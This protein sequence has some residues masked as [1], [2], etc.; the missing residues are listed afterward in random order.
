MAFEEQENQ[1]VA[2]WCCVRGGVL[3]DWDR[4]VPETVGVVAVSSKYNF[5]TLL[6]VSLS[7]WA[8]WY[9]HHRKVD[10]GW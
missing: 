4:D 7:W 6:C 3:L 9:S 10:Q 2:V 1:V 5:M 8:V